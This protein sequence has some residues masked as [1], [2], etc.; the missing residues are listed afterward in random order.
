MPTWDN[1]KQ[2]LAEYDGIATKLFAG[3][4]SLSQLPAVM[5]RSANCQ[6][7]LRSVNGTTQHLE[8][9]PLVRRNYSG[10]RNYPRPCVLESDGPSSESDGCRV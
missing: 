6:Y 3:G 10:A 2:L 4:L 1:A 5:P 9:Y 7:W 8:V